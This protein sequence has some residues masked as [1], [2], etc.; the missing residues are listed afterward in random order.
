MLIL[1]E[2]KVRGFKAFKDEVWFKI[3]KPI[4]ILTGPI[5]SGKS[6][7]LDA[8]EYGLY[9]RTKDVRRRIIKREDLIND[10]SNKLQVSLTLE[11]DKL[12]SIKITREYSRNGLSQV[13]L[14]LNNEE[15]KGD[16]AESKIRELTGLDVD[17]FSRQVFVNHI[18][19]QNI[20]YGSPYSR[21]IVIDKLLGI[22]VLEK[23]FRIIQLREINEKINELE[24]NIKDISQELKNLP[25]A[26][27][28]LKDKELLDK[29]LKELE[30]E[31]EK[32]KRN[33]EK[34][35]QELKKYEELK[36]KYVT[37]KNKR[38]RVET[39]LKEYKSLLEKARSQ[40]RTSSYIE[41]VEYIRDE[42]IQLLENLYLEKDAEELSKVIIDEERILEIIKLLEEKLKKALK[43]RERLI[44]EIGEISAEKELKMRRLKEI[45]KEVVTLEIKIEELESLNKKY[46]DLVNKY[47]N[48]GSVRK[49]ISDLELKLRKLEE[50]QGTLSCIVELQRGLLSSSVLQKLKCPV[51]KSNITNTK[52]ENIKRLFG[53]ENIK[54]K[55]Y[56]TLKNKLKREIKD[57][58]RVLEEMDDLEK[59][60]SANMETKSRY[61]TLKEKFEELMK[62]YEALEENL[63]EGERR[64]S[65]I[66]KVARIV[67]KNINNVKNYIDTLTLREK[68]DKFEKEIKVLDKEISELGFEEEEY[69]DLRE[70]IYELRTKLNTIRLK[71]EEIISKMDSIDS[72]ISLVK[73]LENERLIN[74][75][76]LKKLKYLAET[77]L[78]VKNT[79]RSVQA[80]IRREALEK[81]KTYMNDAFSKIYTYEDYDLLDVKVLRVKEGEYE[82]SIY[83]LYAR[84][85]IDNRWIP[86]ATRLSDGQKMIVALCLIAALFKLYT[87]NIAFLILD[88]PTPNVD[89]EIKKAIIR[90]LSRELGVRQIILATQSVEAIPK[91]D[92][93]IRVKNMKELRGSP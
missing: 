67:N 86:I 91:Q 3:D 13:I 1:R 88:E 90:L 85:T 80:V 46:D 81:I 38:I 43:E 24:E 4:F 73:E 51:C 78:K 82:R 36:S 25:E 52:I 59:Y 16:R 26:E 84:R 57:L 32:L 72:D 31:E 6:S 44:R 61:E 41:E 50:E 15:L 49:K 11:E 21:S 47:G 33:I 70:K 66:T 29:K 40:L 22:D 27:D 62:D 68:I 55:T 20:I 75:K 83:E 60:L 89:P 63:K 7:I 5:G 17:D 56:Y 64:L 87:H 42:L 79:F 35:E 19:L 71:K 65:E 54:L 34:Y 8:I 74:E 93:N 30:A 12:G 28:L 53:E 48:R 23:I 92:E 9:G 76:R 58:K 69:L 39:L 14:T 10:F 18:D 77:L 45:E 2:I 37:L